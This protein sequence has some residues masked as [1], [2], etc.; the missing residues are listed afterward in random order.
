MKSID[1]F[2]LSAQRALLGNIT[3]N[4]R[5]ISVLLEGDSITLNFFMM[6]SLVKMMK[7]MLL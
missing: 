2:K 4:T 1:Y 3:K 5:A 6:E 7:K